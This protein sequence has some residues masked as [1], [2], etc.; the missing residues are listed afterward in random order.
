[1]KR[2][3]LLVSL[4]ML[5]G[6]LLF[7]V[8]AQAQGTGEP[9]V[10]YVMPSC[11]DG[12]TLCFETIQAAMDAE[13]DVVYVSSGIYY[14]HNIS[15]DHN[16]TI[17]ADP[18]PVVIDA[19]GKG[20][21][22]VSGA[23]TFTL[24]GLTLYD[25]KAPLNDRGKRESGGF[26]YAP[27][28]DVVLRDVV[29]EYRPFSQYQIL[30]DSFQTNGTDT[31]DG[32]DTDIEYSQGGFIHAG[33]LT[34]ENSHL[35]GGI[36]N[37]HTIRVGHLEVEDSF[38]MTNSIIENG[39]CGPAVHVISGTV[40]MQ[41]STIKQWANRCKAWTAIG[42]GDGAGLVL[43]AEVNDTNITGSSFKY[44]VSDEGSGIHY[45][46]WKDHTYFNVHD[47][48]FVG[49]VAR[50]PMNSTSL[51]DEVGGAIF[52]SAPYSMTITNSSFR[53]N[54]AANR[55]GAIHWGSATGTEA[56]VLIK[57]CEFTANGLTALNP[58]WTSV[59]G[60]AI[61]AAGHFR[62]EDSTFQGHWGIKAGY[63]L[64]FR[65]NKTEAHI[66]NTRIVSNTTG[67]IILRDGTAWITNTVIA[68]SGFARFTNDLLHLRLPFACIVAAEPITV[69]NSTLHNCGHI[70]GNDI[71]EANWYWP[72]G[73]AGIFVPWDTAIQNPSIVTIRNTAITGVDFPYTY[74]VEDE[75]GRGL[76]FNID[77]YN[78]HPTVMT[79]QAE[80]GGWLRG[81]MAY[82]DPGNYDLRITEASDAKDMGNPNVAPKRDLTGR[83]RDGLPDIGAYEA[84][85][86]CTEIT[87]VSID[88]TFTAPDIYTFTASPTPGYADDGS[89]QYTWDNGDTGTTST[90]I[91]PVGVHTVTVEAENA[92][93]AVKATTHITVA[94]QCFPVTDLRVTQ[95]PP[96]AVYSDTL[97]FHIDMTPAYATPPYTY[98]IDYQDSTVLGIPGEGTILLDP[99]PTF[100]H[101]FPQPGTYNVHIMI[102]NC[103][104]GL[105]HIHPVR[106]YAS[107]ASFSNA[108]LPLVQRK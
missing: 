100:T 106:I 9:K 54:S 103:N 78:G 77:H 12:L 13:T 49:N 93:S 97:S 61:F 2:R 35:Q 101:K 3:I 44:L 41:D 22:F 92:C 6:W 46:L 69:T 24:E 55:A 94:P 81:F 86:P 45:D 88:H 20:R 71:P 15:V 40:T 11:P 33:S 50:K 26:I 108:Y 28:T 74:Q 91:L 48:E 23:D 42:G 73:S 18:Q 31:P 32:D 70:W 43:E 102:Q 25:G 27:N 38:T 7:P 58:Y 52:A 65:G 57:D 80:E 10:A 17:T 1:M 99:T 29:V 8:A 82:F 104:D 90:R 51:G 64:E 30:F 56:D 36:G 16:V 66:V 96:F 34:L 19:E 68:D 37:A 63:T 83:L 47:S 76:S 107:D 95:S 105:I 62:I 39:L 98:T 84:A 60:S 59:G 72:G 85:P 67:G 75:H 21:V 5:A 87:D 89:I 53:L 14:E 4:V 79:D